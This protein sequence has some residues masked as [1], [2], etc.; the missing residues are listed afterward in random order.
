V[1]AQQ[2]EQPRRGRGR[3]VGIA[4]RNVD[5]GKPW[6]RNTRFSGLVGCDWSKMYYGFYSNLDCAIG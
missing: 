5:S 6:R 3:D 2:L 1:H 4:V